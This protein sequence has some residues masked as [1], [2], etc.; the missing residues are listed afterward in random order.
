[1]KRKRLAIIISILL[2]VAAV[3][4]PVVPVVR[5]DDFQGDLSAENQGDTELQGN[6]AV[7]NEGNTLD[8]A[9]LR[10]APG[11]QQSRQPHTS[12]WR[13]THE[14]IAQSILFTKH[15]D[16]RGL[17]Q[18]QVSG[19]LSFEITSDDTA[20]KRYEVWDRSDPDSPWLKAGVRIK[21]G[22]Y[23]YRYEAPFSSE[24]YVD[25]IFNDLARGSIADNGNSLALYNRALLHEWGRAV[26][27]YKRVYTISVGKFTRSNF[28]YNSDYEDALN[29]RRRVS[30]DNGDDPE[31]FIMGTIQTSP[32]YDLEN[33]TNLNYQL[34]YYD[35]Y[36]SLNNYAEFLNG[37][38]DLSNIEALMGNEQAA[39]FLDC[40][41]RPIA[42]NKTYDAEGNILSID[43]PLFPSARVYDFLKKLYDAGTFYSSEYDEELGESYY[44]IYRFRLRETGMQID[45]SNIDLEGDGRS[46]ILDVYLSGPQET[47][48]FMFDSEDEA[49]NFYQTRMDEFENNQSDYNYFDLDQ[50][51]RGFCLDKVKPVTLYNWLPRTSVSVSKE[52]KDDENKMGKRPSS[53]E[54]HLLADGQMTDRSI[55]L[56]EENNWQGSFDDLNR[57]SY[58]KDPESGKI[59]KE[60]IDYQISETPVPHYESHVHT[61]KI[62]NEVKEFVLTN[63]YTDDIVSIDVDTRWEDDNNKD[64]KRPQVITVLLLKNGH[65]V[66]QRK[67]TEA[68]EWKVSFKDLARYD[69]NGRAIQYSI[70]E[71]PIEGYETEIGGFQIVNKKACPPCNPCGQ[72]PSNPCNPSQACNPSQPCPPE[73]S[74]NS[75][76]PCGSQTCEQKTCQVGIVKSCEPHDSSSWPL[77]DAQKTSSYVVTKPAESKASTPVTGTKAPQSAGMLPVTA[78]GSWTNV[79]Y[80]SLLLLL[81]GLVTGLRYEMKRHKE[82]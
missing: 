25:P 52:W 8:T 75:V 7:E 9:T 3:F 21:P 10:R 81:A 37:T 54:V 47:W 68:D 26:S 33:I 4:Q 55:T 76:T 61:G 70:Y 82:N 48:I 38:M 23:S 71:E 11:G 51:D 78:D 62:L 18:K 30:W 44:N 72:C 60:L 1:M 56:S 63:T 58:T 80:A 36:R 74:C 34:G 41:T 5:A 77:T 17:G 45:N 29:N 35:S 42:T 57:F 65:V 67:L 46:L 43:K 27:E 24:D 73:A 49:N 2:L 28:E 32:P 59:S 53:V 69:E 13:Y 6:I 14:G 15:I 64:K 40:I 79:L 20:D 19:K 31:T 50:P 16:L 66:D 12:E 39:N 22:Q